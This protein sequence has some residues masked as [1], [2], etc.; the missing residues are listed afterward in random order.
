MKIIITSD[1]HIQNT[2]RFSRPG[3]HGISDR[4]QQSFDFLEWLGELCKKEEVSIILHCG[5]LF[6]QKNL[7]TTPLFNAAFDSIR[8]LTNICPMIMVTGNHD[9]YMKDRGDLLYNVYTFQEG[10]D[11]FHVIDHRAGWT[12]VRKDMKKINVWGLS[13][14]EEIGQLLTGPFGKDAGG[15]SN[16]Y[17]LLIMHDGITG[18][19]YPAGSS[20]TDGFSLDDLLNLVKRFNVRYCFC[21]DIHRAQQLSDNVVVIGSPFQMDFGD[22][23]QSRGVWILDVDEDLL[24]FTPYLHGPMY[25]TICDEDFPDVVSSYEDLVE[26][27]NLYWRFRLSDRSSIRWITDNI[28]GNY[29]IDPVVESE[30]PEEMVMSGDVHG[31]ISGYVEKVSTGSTAVKNRLKSIGIHY[32]DMVGQD[33]NLLGRNQIRYEKLDIRNF[34]SF[35][36]QTVLLDNAGLVLISG[37]N[38]SGKT[39]LFSLAIPWVLYGIISTS[40]EVLADDV[41]NNKVG[42]N[43]YGK[44]SFS[45]E[46][47]KYRVERYRS[48]KTHRNSLHLYDISG[49]GERNLT[50]D[51]IPETQKRILDICREDY[52]GYLNSNIFGQGKVKRFTECTDAERRQILSNYLRLDTFTEARKKL[53]PDLDKLSM[54]IFKLNQKV[55]IGRGRIE[56]LDNRTQEELDRLQ[57]VHNDE[58]AE[59]EVRE[60]QRLEE[61]IRSKTSLLEEEREIHKKLEESKPKEPDIT[62]DLL[63]KN[64]GKYEERIAN[65]REAE[66]STHCP[67]CG[68]KYPQTQITKQK[69]EIR[70]RLLEAEAALDKLQQPREIYLEIERIRDKV[71]AQGQLVNRTDRELYEL[72][73][74]HLI[75]TRSVNS[76]YKVME[77][78]ESRIQ[79]L[80][81]DRDG[82]IKS[83]VTVLMKLKELY[84]DRRALQFWLEGFGNYGIRDFCFDSYIN[85]VNQRLEY[86]SAKIT[87]SC[88]GIRIVRTDAGKIT[89]EVDIP[90]AA[91]KYSTASAGQSK[92]VDLCVALAFQSFSQH[93][94]QSS[95]IVVFDEFESSLDSDGVQAFVNFLHEEQ[96]HKDSIFVITHNRE[97]ESYF[98]RV[99]TMT[100]KE[101]ESRLLQGE[102]PE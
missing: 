43:C 26:D 23:G 33:R 37:I 96:D 27:G 34:W 28:P 8:N 54:E 58:E 81:G 83:T 66:V 29:I 70:K 82:L 35:K 60:L 46:D 98:D 64:I 20:V 15:D 14:G 80:Q 63:R 76:R 1:T 101:G 94:F 59:R 75:L 102:H 99:W 13:A 41:I 19:L 24:K 88:Y 36:R 51:T 87:G 6:T 21:G 77:D 25:V 4:A 9:R 17:N 48:H 61:D 12:F 38:G 56:D 47:R 31:F 84:R 97:L 85:I 62:I 68:R 57:E 45:I 72:K 3:K 18:A 93:Q 69:A 55:E 5:D 16:E 44:L 100:Y 39:A 32:Y 95:N 40:T 52:L 50:C 11:N 73:Q 49:G 65:L 7:I 30:K 79:K 89:I 92:R 91:K 74:R 90:N 86:Y 2:S 78:I 67:T 42:R 22:E 53:K 10:I 71:N